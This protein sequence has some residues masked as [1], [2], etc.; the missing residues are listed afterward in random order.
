[1]CFQ[2]N[3]PECTTAILAT[4]SNPLMLARAR[5]AYYPFS[6]IKNLPAVWRAR[7]FVQDNHGYQLR[8]EYAG[9]VSFACQDL[10]GEVPYSGEQQVCDLIC[11]RNLAFTYFD[12]DLQRQTLQR[13]RQVLLEGGVLLIGVHETLPAGVEGFL[14]WSARL[15]VYRR[16]G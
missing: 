12:E 7:A 16:V 3:H 8:G 5:E 13:L 15:G 2:D 6:A 1:M 9:R 10:R 11:C 4:D 14:P